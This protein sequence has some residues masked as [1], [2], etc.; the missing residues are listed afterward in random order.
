MTE[1]P[2]P[3][4]ASLPTPAIVFLV[5]NRPEQTRQSLA[6]IRQAQPARLLVVADGPRPDRPSEKAACAE[7]R[8]VVK[9]G[10]NWDT[11]A[12]FNFADTNLGLRTRVSSGLT[13][14][15]EQVEEALI[16]EDDC[17]VQ[18]TLFPYGAELLERYRHDERVGCINGTNLLPANFLFD[19]SYCFSR[20]HTPTGWA[21]WRRAWR[22]YDSQMRLFNQ[23]RAAGWFEAWFPN[24]RHRVYWERCM[25][26]VYDGRTS[27]WAYVWWMSCWANSMLAVNPCVNLVRNIGFGEGG[28]HTQDPGDWMAH[29]PVGDMTF[30]LRHPELVMADSRADACFLDLRGQ[31]SLKRLLKMQVRSWWSRATRSPAKKNP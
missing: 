21:T 2:R 24:P 29:L 8:R 19:A 20:W 13:W 31:A 22:L 23:A 26:R 1:L 18:P 27:S 14:A 7:V 5:F 6:A 16:I 25:E 9:E 15:F 28:T 10:I 11:D 4:G 3:P 12:R 30:P 17:V